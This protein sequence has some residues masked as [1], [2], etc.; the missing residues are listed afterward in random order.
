VA[1][2]RYDTNVSDIVDDM[3]EEVENL[4]DSLIDIQKE[5]LKA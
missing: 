3:T 5:V 4:V 1:Y 2:S